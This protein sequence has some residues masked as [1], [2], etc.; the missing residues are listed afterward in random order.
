MEFKFI[1]MIVLLFSVSS[2]IEEEVLPEQEDNIISLEVL[3][4]EGIRHLPRNE[5]VNPKLYEGN[6]YVKQSK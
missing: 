5:V 6:G 4:E 2:Y 3:R 1:T